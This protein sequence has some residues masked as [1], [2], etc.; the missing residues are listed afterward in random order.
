MEKKYARK[1]LRKTV[2]IA[3][4]LRFSQYCNLAPSRRP[5]AQGERGDLF[6]RSHRPFRFSWQAGRR[7]A[8]TPMVTRM[9]ETKGDPPR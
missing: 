7:E 3:L 8:K 4:T 9:V 6:S 5:G 1:D 2:T